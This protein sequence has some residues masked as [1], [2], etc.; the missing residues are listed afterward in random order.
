M[1]SSTSNTLREFGDVLQALPH[2]LYSTPCEVLNN[3]TI[4]QHTRHI[5]ELYQCLLSGFD[6]GEVC[7][8][9][10]QRDKRIEADVQFALISIEAILDKIERKDK[11][12]KVVYELD[13]KEVILN[14]NYRREVMYN[15]E[16]TIHHQAL[17]RVALQALSAV[18]LPDSF[19]VAPSTLRYRSL[20]AQ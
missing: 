17:I 3:S 9:K 12:L 1:F 18:P 16:H 5:I 11:S 15:L 2:G 14:S 4:G 10:R 7:Y 13:G 6:T 8:D 20:C 19:G